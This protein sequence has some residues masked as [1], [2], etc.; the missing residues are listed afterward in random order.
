MGIYP[1]HESSENQMLSFTH[2]FELRRD[3]LCCYAENIPG[4][5]LKMGNCDSS[6]SQKW[7]HKKVNIKKNK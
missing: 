6:E 2:K 3:D 5:P 4:S 7:T 1:C